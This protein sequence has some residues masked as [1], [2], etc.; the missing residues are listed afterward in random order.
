MLLALELLLVLMLP[1]ARCLFHEMHR[2]GQ[3]TNWPT[4]LMQAHC[5]SSWIGIRR[6]KIASVKNRKTVRGNGLRGM[7]L[8]MKRQDWKLPIRSRANQ[9]EDGN[10]AE[11]HTIPWS[12]VYLIFMDLKY[13]ELV[14]M[15]HLRIPRKSWR[16]CDL[17]ITSFQMF[18]IDQPI[19]RHHPLG[20]RS[21]G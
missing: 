4:T 12:L 1:K 21:A 2:A 10:P 8:V 6:E 13:T 18:L 3:S 5:D 16:L 17:G 11:E 14:T 19:T 15:T 9:N 7:L 20:T